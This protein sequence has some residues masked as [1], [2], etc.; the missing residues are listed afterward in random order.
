MSLVWVFFG[1]VHASA[2]ANDKR[3]E[4][5]TLSPVRTELSVTPGTAKT[6]KLTVTNSTSTDMP[7]DMS[8]E[9]FGVK[10]SSYAYTFDPDSPVVDWMRFEP[11][12]F[13]LAPGKD[14][15][16]TYTMSVPP[17]GEVGGHY[18]ALFASTDSK[19]GSGTLVSRQ[20]V[21]SLLYV[22][23][24]GDVTKTGSLLSI[25]LP[26]TTTGE[27]TWSALVQNTGTAHFRS[28]YDV[29]VQTLWNSEVMK[30]SGDALILPGSIRQVKDDIPS[31]NIP[32]IYKVVYVVSLGD[33][34]TAYSTRYMLVMPIY[35]WIIVGLV[36]IYSVTAVTRRVV[37]RV[38]SKKS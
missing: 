6:G 31:I 28:N 24:E 9:V 34:P 38:Q 3:T 20:R 30:L 23:V 35:G 33:S 4:G 29:T 15:T 18:I 36:L 17:E 12:S 27:T 25:A 13:T 7:V 1:F 37:T 22:T 16:V 32:G 21:T 19:D 8:A 5:L 26:W 11:S 14:Q 2:Q 10:D